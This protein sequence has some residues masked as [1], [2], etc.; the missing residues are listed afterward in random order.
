MPRTTGSKNKFRKSEWYTPGYIV[1]VIRGKHPDSWFW[2]IGINPNKFGS[3][4]FSSFWKDHC[5]NKDGTPKYD[6]REK[7]ISKRKEF[8]G[9]VAKQLC[10][11]YESF[12]DSKYKKRIDKAQSR[13][14]EIPI[15]NNESKTKPQMNVEK[16][17]NTIRRQVLVYKTNEMSVELIR[18]VGEALVEFGTKLMELTES[19]S[20]LKESAS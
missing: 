5:I 10:E 17:C 8:R 11:D 1:E 6:H 4:H 12:L 16:T 19:A 2:T 18:G 14:L 7:G 13:Q 3:N 15:E 20:N 9:D